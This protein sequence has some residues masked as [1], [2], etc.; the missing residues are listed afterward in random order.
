MKNLFANKWVKFALT[1]IIY[2]LFVIWTENYWLL[3]GFLVIYDVFISQKVHWAFWKKKGVEKQTKTVE[4]IDALIFAIVAAT[5]IRLFFIE[6]F[7]IPTSSMEKSLLVGDYLFVSKFNYGP[8]MPNT[9]LSVPFTHNTMPFSESAKSYLDWI[10]WPYHRLKGLSTVKNNDVV[11]FNFPEGDTVCLNQQARSYYQLIRDYGRDNV[12]NDRI[13]DSYGQ[14][15]T[16]YFGKRVSRP[17]DK[18]E[19]YIKRCVAIAGDSLQVIDGQAFVN[20]KP[21]E[22]IGDKQFKYLV[23]T[24]GTMINPKFFDELGISRED[25][26]AS[27][28]FD[29]S[30]TEFMSETQGVNVNNMFVYP[31]VKENVEKIKALPCVKSVTRIIKPKGFRETYIFPHDERYRW[32]EDNFGPLYVPKRGAT[33]QLTLDNLPLYRRIIETYEENKVSVSGGQILINNQPATEYTFKMDY[34]FMMGDSRHNSADSRFW[35]FVPEDHVVG[36]ALFIWFSTDK[37]KSFLS[38]IRWS[39]VFMGIK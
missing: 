36:K 19:N 18:R 25:I 2:L 22:E 4:W 21:Q 3:L 31:L 13:R 7:T 28:L 12:V 26:E 30:I 17:V 8:K 23:I 10:K 15:H 20:G 16:G 1:A 9:P 37:D 35:G 38:S 32:N 6:A 29:P 39:R 34:Y 14:V 33:I 27:R 24:D 11:V 5:I